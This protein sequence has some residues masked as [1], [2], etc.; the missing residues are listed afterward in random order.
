MSNHPE[1][2]TAIWLTPR[3]QPPSTHIILNSSLLTFKPLLKY[4]LNSSFQCISRLNS[5]I[6]R[7]VYSINR[8]PILKAITSRTIAYILESSTQLAQFPNLRLDF[9]TPI[10]SIEIGSQV[11][12]ECSSLTPNTKVTWL[13]D[14]RYTFLFEIKMNYQGHLI[15]NRKIYIFGIKDLLDS[16]IFSK[17]KILLAKMLCENSSV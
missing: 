12:I 11:E 15:F 8:I 4:H 2:I 3:T 9:R 14:N 17:A 6:T 7:L 10:E 13:L 16:R 1:N 5:T